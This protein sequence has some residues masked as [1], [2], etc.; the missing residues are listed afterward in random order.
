MLC[1]LYGEGDIWYKNPKNYARRLYGLPKKGLSTAVGRIEEV[2][3]LE[4]MKSVID[5][6]DL[7]MEDFNQQL[8]S[9]NEIF[10]QNP[11][12][13]VLP[14]QEVLELVDLIYPAAKIDCICRRLA[15]ATQENSKTYS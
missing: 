11:M 8:Q 6:K 12:G 1:E 4:L 9:V 13:Q 15:R 5:A 7:S 10:M 2:Q 3:G 14:L